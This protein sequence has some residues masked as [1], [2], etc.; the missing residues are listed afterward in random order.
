[1]SLWDYKIFDLII[2]EGSM[3]KTAE[4][5]HLTPAAISHSL[6]KLEA[7]FGLPL[8]VRGRGAVKLT[9]YGR[10]LL[11]HIRM[12]LSADARLHAELDR[13]KGDMNG[14]VR[15]GAI[16]SVCCAWLPAILQRMRQ[17]MPDVDVQ[18]FQAGYD[19]LEDAL[20]DGKL[21][22]AFVSLPTRKRLTS[23]SLLHDR[24][25]C[26]TPRDFVPKNVTYITI[27]E[28]KRFQLIIPGPGSD[29]DAIAFMEANGLGTETVHSVSED[30]SIIALVESGLGVSIMPELV[31][32]KNGGDIGVYPIESAP[33]R[34][35]GI[36]TNPNGRQTMP[37]ST[38]LK[39][40]IDYVTALYPKEQP[41]FRK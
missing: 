22:L 2:S 7:E 14:L 40:I 19:E 4:Q 20:L 16:N 27:D 28:I 23:V 8:I 30:S 10:A 5:M 3:R 31:L 13:I 33:Y 11:P 15:I 6:A 12:T 21:D 17:V 26:I 32:Q 34:N 35:I 18:V 39:I 29:F 38:S 25:L 36:S 37:V 9:E 24:L 1:M 41:Y